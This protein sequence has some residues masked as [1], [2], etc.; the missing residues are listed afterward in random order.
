MICSKLSVSQHFDDMST[1][2]K[3]LKLPLIQLAATEIVSGVSGESE[4]KVRE[5]FQEAMV[6][7]MYDVIYVVF[8]VVCIGGMFYV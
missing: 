8:R 4:E 7:C 2:Y 3:E 5:I 6:C 1:F